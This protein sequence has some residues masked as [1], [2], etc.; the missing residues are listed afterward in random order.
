MYKDRKRKGYEFDPDG[1]VGKLAIKL[2]DETMG[3]MS[4]AGANLSVEEALNDVV[5]LHSEATDKTW[6]TAWVIVTT[7]TESTN[8]E[9][10]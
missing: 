8:E 7:R 6:E 4:G 5:R 10:K 3:Y 2:A 1:L 9:T